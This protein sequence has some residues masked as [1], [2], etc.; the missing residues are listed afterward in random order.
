M[1]NIIIEEHEFKFF[2]TP[3]KYDFI[4]GTD[5]LKKMGIKLNY[6]NLV[7]EWADIKQ[8]MNT[9]VF[10]KGRIHA[11]I[12]NYHLLM[13]EEEFNDDFDVIDSYASSILDAKY[14]EA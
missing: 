10:M 2:S 4:L 14:K 3:C 9:N 13:E 5:F 8:P 12:D 11:F 7:I 1:S 6:E